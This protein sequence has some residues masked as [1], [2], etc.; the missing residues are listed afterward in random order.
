[1]AKLELLCIHCTATPDQRQVYPEDI[2]KW[3]LGPVSEGG[4]GWKQVGYSDM[5]LL[6][7]VV[8][9]LVKYNEDDRVDPWEITNG[10]TGI[11]SKTRHVVYVGGTDK[12]GNPKD[13]RNKAQLEAL[14][15]YV[16][17]FISKHP[18]AKVCGHNQFAQKACPSFDTVAWLRSI[19]FPENNI[20]IK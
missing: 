17:D 19:G 18:T 7:G 16:W 4:R 12:K 11:N 8:V 3:H 6:N 1:M 20:Y 13:T 14:T 15:D 9:N 2:R 10:A 5:I